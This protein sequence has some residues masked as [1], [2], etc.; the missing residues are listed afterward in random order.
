[1]LHCIADKSVQLAFNNNHSLTIC[2]I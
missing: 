2:N 1:M